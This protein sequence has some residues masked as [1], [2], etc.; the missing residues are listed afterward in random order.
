MKEQQWQ[1]DHTML[2]LRVNRLLG[3]GML[4]YSGP[5][6][7][8]AAAESEPPADPGELAAEADR[9]L[10]LAPSAYLAA[11]VRALR[12]VA[13]RLDGERLPLSEY[14]R[15]C[16]G[17]EPRRLPE[18]VF[19]QA[20]AE[21]DAA[22]PKTGGSL[23]GRMRTWQAAHTLEPM[24]RLPELAARAVAET[25][26]RTSAIVPLPAEK[27]EVRLVEGVAFHAAGDYEGGRKSTIHVNKAIPFNV[28]DLLYVIAHEGHPGHIAESMLKEDLDD[29]RVRFMLS[30]SFA[31]SEGLGLLAE[32]IVFPGDEA[33]TWLDEHILPEAGV[34]PDG[35]DLAAIHHAKN[36]L[37]GVWGNAVFMAHEGRSEAELAA[38]LRRWALYGESEVALAMGLIQ[39]S[40][41]SPYLLAYF[42]GWE[43]LRSWATTRDRVRRLLTEQLLPADIAP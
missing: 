24:E 13:R 10:E 34:R 22:L 35:S 14:A 31:L 32:E 12:A 25:R 36:V 28:A 5:Q 20:H 42:H 38:Y 29:Q 8:R 23:A 2:A 16:L 41:T 9:L 7:W 11:Q 39:P 19:E 17:L 15:E 37:W 4:I 30:P 26:A 3:G 27:V 21:L 33:R 1:H 40:P 18:E 43:L 6:E